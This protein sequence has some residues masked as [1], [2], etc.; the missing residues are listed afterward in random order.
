MVATLFE[1]LGEG[2]AGLAEGILL[3]LGE[4]CAGAA[5][6]AEED[7][8]EEEGAAG[9]AAIAALGAAVRWLT[10]EA[11]LRVLPLR[12]QEV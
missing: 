11:V 4:L 6:A 2:S 8:V 12:L 9:K 3:R 1:R 10:P 7:A 5:E